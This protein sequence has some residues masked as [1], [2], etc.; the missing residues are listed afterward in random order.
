VSGPYAEGGPLPP[1]DR[2]LLAEHE[3]RL[4][5]WEDEIAR[6]VEAGRRQDEPS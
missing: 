6:R 3:R 4:E 2:E 1:V 5:E